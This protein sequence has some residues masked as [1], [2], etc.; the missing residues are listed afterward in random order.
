M[1]KLNGEPA[2]EG[3]VDERGLEGVLQFTGKALKDAP[4]E[5]GL[6]A[7]EVLELCEVPRYE[8]GPDPREKDPSDVAF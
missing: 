1:L 6:R 4:A 5:G 8:I 7:I 2:I 3:P